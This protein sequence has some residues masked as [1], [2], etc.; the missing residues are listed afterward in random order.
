LNAH[1]GIQIKEVAWT[2]SIGSDPSHYCG[3]MDQNIGL[4]F[5]DQPIGG[6]SGGEIEI[7]TSD[8][9][10]IGTP[11]TPKFIDDVAAQEARAAG[12]NNSFIR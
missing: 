2:V 7:P 1:D 12:Y 3:G 9:E 6:F 10:R 8:N 5:A 11:N 4:G